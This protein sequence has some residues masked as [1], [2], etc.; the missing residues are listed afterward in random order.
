MEDTVRDAFDYFLDT[1]TGDVIILSED[2]INKAHAVLE[3]DFDED[4]ADY[5]EVIFDKEHDIPDWMEEEVELAL[6]IFL[7][8]P[9]RYV[10]IPERRSQSG[11]EAMRQFTERLEDLELKEQLMHILDGQG[12]FRRFKDA[13]DQYPKEK[14]AWYGFNAKHS[15][16][17]ITDWLKTAGIEY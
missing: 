15:K 16:K 11:F 14:K 2:I 10:R 4:I 13:L 8:E 17:E 1:E 9:E 6:D 3:E 12:A 7:N 5:E